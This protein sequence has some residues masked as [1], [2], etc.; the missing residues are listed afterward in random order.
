MRVIFELSMPRNNSWNNRWSGEKD[1]YTVAKT[2]TPKKFKSLDDYY[3]YD[4]GD[5]WMAGVGVRAAKPR[6]KASG[7]F[8]GYEW[9]ISSILCKG[10]IEAK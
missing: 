2:I 4:F 5:G 8:C 10:C 1:I 9:M 3:T 6:E 7:K